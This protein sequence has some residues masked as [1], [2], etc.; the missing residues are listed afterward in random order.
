[1]TINPQTSET[2]SAFLANLA[3]LDPGERA[4][5]RRSAGC[6]LAEARDVLALFYRLLPYG[7]P[8]HQE[9][10]YFLVATLYPLAE[11]TDNGDL[12]ASL[13]RARSKANAKGMDRRVQS[14]LDADPE[15]LPFRLRQAVNFLQSNRVRVNWAQLLEDLLQ[16]NH[17]ERY[18]Q[19][20]WARSYFHLEPTQKTQ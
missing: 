19:P 6:T 18:I 20:R 13:G 16:W 11:T 17:P 9:E 8:A 12:G 3:K 5:L 14:L 15:Q 2:V 7:V 4:R 10:T 1:M